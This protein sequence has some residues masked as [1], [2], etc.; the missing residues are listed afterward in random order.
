[1]FISKIKILQITFFCVSLNAINEQ[2]MK[3]TSSCH[4]CDYIPKVVGAGQIFT[5]GQTAYQFMHNGIKIVKNCYSRDPEMMTA[6]IKNL[7]GHHE[8]QEEKCFF[9]VLKS[10]PAGAVMIELGSWWA[11]YSMWFQRTVPNAINFM[12]EPEPSLLEIGRKNFDLNGMHGT[13]VQAFVDTSSAEHAY[14]TD[15]FNKERFMKRICIDDFLDIN[16][17]PFVHI[18]HSDIQ[19]AEYD[20]LLGTQKSIASH[21]IGYFFISTHSDDIHNKCYNFLLKNGFKI[22]AVHTVRESYSCDGLIVA[23]SKYIN[24]VESITVSKRPNRTEK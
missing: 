12:I 11:Y 16:H 15:W 19:G 3:L 20:M 7:K 13:F 17:I 2:R 6:I 18:L 14:Y 10:M 5:E 1:M 24:G 22:V 23:K 21:K 4:D 9:E 8:P